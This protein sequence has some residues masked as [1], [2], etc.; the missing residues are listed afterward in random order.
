MTSR[1]F[2]ELDNDDVFVD[3]AANDVNDARLKEAQ[4]EAQDVSR[5]STIAIKQST[6]LHPCTWHPD[7]S[8]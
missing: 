8:D 1:E 4:D 3:A 7:S 6:I 2:G 5:S